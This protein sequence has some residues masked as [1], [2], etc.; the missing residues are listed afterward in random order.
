VRRWKF[1]EIDAPQRSPEWK[2]ARAGRLTASRAKDMLAAIKSGEAAARRDLRVQLVVERLTGEP[3]DGDFVNADMQR[4]LELEAD[5]FA[6]YEAVTGQMAA[7][8]GFLAH[9]ELLIGC[10]PDGVLDNF[11]GL[12]ELKVPRSATHLAYLRSGSVPPEHRAQLVHALWVTGAA[13]IDFLSFDPRFPSH[14]QTFY[15][16]LDRDEKEIAEYAAKALAFLAEV[17]RDLQVV[18]T[19]ADASAQM[20]AV[21]A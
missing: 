9:D 15:V 6:A 2:R 13:Y 14:L 5:A 19:L 16:R 4:G 11:G 18:T 8:C 3:Q 20:R 10:S 7:R 12:L 21:V 17:D 1:T